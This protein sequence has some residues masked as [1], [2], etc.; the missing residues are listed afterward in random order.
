[1]SWEPVSRSRKI[2]PRLTKFEYDQC[3]AACDMLEQK[4]LSETGMY[5]ISGGYSEANMTRYTRNWIYLRLVW[6]VSS[7]CERRR[8]IERYKLDRMELPNFV[9]GPSRTET[10]RKILNDMQFVSRKEEFQDYG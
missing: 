10:C 2:C 7:D 9:G 6:G 1:M 4:T 3:N 5:R 8:T